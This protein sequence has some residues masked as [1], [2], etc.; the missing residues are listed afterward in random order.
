M[1][2]LP[3]LSIFPSILVHCSIFWKSRTYTYICAILWLNAHILT[4][5]GIFGNKQEYQ[6]LWRWSKIITSSRNICTQKYETRRIFGQED[7]KHQPKYEHRQNSE[8]VHVWEG[9]RECRAWL[10][11]G[12]RFVTEESWR[13]ISFGG[14]WFGGD[15]I[16][17]R[18][19][20]SLLHVRMSHEARNIRWFCRK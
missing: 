3:F 14:P 9:V 16:R 2:I 5:S 18:G 4:I 12:C 6:K 15:F 7:K 1:Y 19:V 13:E 10:S 8:W 11:V 17:E 20:I